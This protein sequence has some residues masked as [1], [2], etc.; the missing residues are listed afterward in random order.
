MIGTIPN[1]K[2][3]KKEKNPKKNEPQITSNKWTQKKTTPS[4][5]VN[6]GPSLG[7]RLKCGVV[8]QL[9]SHEFVFDLINIVYRY[10]QITCKSEISCS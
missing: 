7:Q 5:D 2:T 4:A 3:K 8:N 10:L 6:P 1:K 9:R